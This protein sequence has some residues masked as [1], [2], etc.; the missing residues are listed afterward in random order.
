[1]AEL[2]MNFLTE[3]ASYLLIGLGVA[4][5]GCLLALKMTQQGKFLVCALGL[6]VLAG[7]VFGF[8]HFWVTDAER[9]EKVVYDLA[10][11]VQASDVERIKIHLDEQVTIGTKDRTMD[12]SAPLRLIF[13]LLQN[14]HFDYVKV[15]QL[16]T[17]VGSQTKM[18]K[19]EFKVTAAGII[20][21]GGTQHLLGTAGSEWDLG[22]R[23]KSPGVWKVTRI[24]AITVPR[25]VAQALFGR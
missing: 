12:G 5:L 24:T 25:E 10:S 9:V 22:F 2:V 13:S 1:M 8:E 18:G 6:L 19:A 15:G 20:E 11:A 7:V 23:E 21:E 17:S 14:S 16:T 4:A 3:D